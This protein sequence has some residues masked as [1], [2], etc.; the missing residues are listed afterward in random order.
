MFETVAPET[1]EVRSKR[2]AYETLPL[3]IALHAIASGSAVV[4]A[5]WTVVFP[6]QSPRLVRAY[7][8]VTI[9]DPPPPPPLPPA[10]KVLPREEVPKPVAPPPQQIVAPTV[11]PDSIPQI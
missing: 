2:L 11:I 1:F 6:A 8:L 9:H 4:V 10:G 5:V 3:S 7:S